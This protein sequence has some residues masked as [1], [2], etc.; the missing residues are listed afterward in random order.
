MTETELLTI[1]DI[2]LS[3][4]NRASGKAEKITSGLINSTFKIQDSSGENYILQRINST[5]FKC[6]EDLSYNIELITSF[7]K[8]SGYPKALIELCRTA[9]NATIIDHHKWGSWRMMKFFEQTTC[10][11]S[12]KRVT[13][14]VQAAKAL[15]EFHSYLIDF[16]AKKL[17]KTIPD[18][19]NFTF[20]LNQLEAS[21]SHGVKERIHSCEEQIAVIKSHYGLLDDYVTL[22]KDLPIRVLHGDPKI[23]NFLFREISDDV[24]ALID[25]DTIIAGP[26]LY[27]FGDMV[28]SFMNPG[29][30]DELSDKDN[31]DVGLY[32][33][34]HGGYLFHLQNKLTPLE[35]D[36]LMLGAKSVTLIQAMRFLT[37]YLVGDIYYQIT[38]KEQNKRR[39][40]NQIRL[41][42]NLVGY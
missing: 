26:V 28:R 30:E 25:W 9:D 7:L 36:N 38:D 1:S 31:F 35:K 14:A 34:I 23:S 41:L 18:F 24:V 27:D 40:M 12:I 17:K 10:V 15:G 21:L 6:P 11:E 16:D 3:T 32:R 33:A 2:F 39:A 29:K 4:V 13:Q 37:D 5:V 8:N 20:R 19:I 22:C 42:K